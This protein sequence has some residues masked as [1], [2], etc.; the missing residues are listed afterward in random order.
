MNTIAELRAAVADYVNRADLSA[1]RIDGFIENGRRMIAQY[2]AR[3]QEMAVVLTLDAE[4]S[5]PLP[6]RFMRVRAVYTAAGVNV[7]QV[8][9]IFKSSDAPGYRI[10]GQDIRVTGGGLVPGSTV[11]LHYFETPEPLDDTTTTTDYLKANGDLWLWAACEDAARYLKDAD[12]IEIAEA[13]RAQIG[14]RV[15]MQANAGRQHNGPR[16]MTVSL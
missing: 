16:R 6:A 4:N 9:S 2:L 15:A 10:I 8:G 1:Q 11:E 3:E 5:A 7:P 14:G 13:A 12:L